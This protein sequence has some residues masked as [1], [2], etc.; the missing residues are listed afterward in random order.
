M[1]ENILNMYE[2]A[3]AEERHHGAMWY[4][5]AG[6]GAFELADAHGLTDDQA[7]AILA[8]L[9]PSNRW[10][11]NVA[12]AWRLCAEGESASVCTYGP[13][14]A[15]A[16]RVLAGECPWDVVT[17][18]K[19]FAFWRCIM[20]DSDAVVIDRHAW[21]I[22]AGSKPNAERAKA[23]LTSRYAEFVEAYVQA[24]EL[25]GI[26]AYEVQ[27]TTWVTFRRI[28]GVAK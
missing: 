20:G 13:N 24:G 3:T 14:K 27:A 25:L 4:D 22:A 23:E 1:L 28:H 5:Q 16:L 6:A 19:V 26:P 7:G 12:D 11:R 18:Q 21:A 17:G 8:L 9:S 2:Q 10:E 15:K